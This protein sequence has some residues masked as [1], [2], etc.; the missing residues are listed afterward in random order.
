MKK[1][2][3]YIG[4]FNSKIGSTL[5]V[6]EVLAP[7]LS[8]DFEMVAVSEVKN[9]WKRLFHMAWTVWKHRRTT[10]FVIIDAYSSSAFWYTWVVAQ[11]CRFSHIPY[12]PILHG[13][14]FPARLKSHPKLTRQ[15]FGHSAINVSPSVYLEQAFQKAGYSVTRIPNAIE[16]G[17]YPFRQ[18]GPVEP[19]LL[20][21]RA[22]AEIYNPIMAVDVLAQIQKQYP[23]ATL[24]MVGQD[25]D[26]TLEKLKKHASQLGVL[27]SITFTG[28]MT[29]AGWIELS[30]EYDIFINTTNF[31]NLP[32]SVIE[33][34]C[35]GFPLVSTN[36][37]GLPFML[38]HE[39][40]ALLVETGDADAMAN[41]VLRLL[42]E[43]EFSQKLSQNAR[44]S[45]EKYAWEQIRT[46]W[47]QTLNTNHAKGE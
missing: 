16:L 27:D 23:A 21:V 31:D 36:A 46:L 30:A 17:M 12:F 14:N 29:K 18:R 32:V 40:D 11:I 4:N 15:V 47:L 35:L 3:V 22:F 7:K 34:Q 20:Y 2:I 10:D 6:I 19:K 42:S 37:G 44:K 39:R 28:Q 24:C 33:A 43:V 45:G 1:K 13:G 26:G 41:A 5:G 8:E 9:Q 38:T 25:K